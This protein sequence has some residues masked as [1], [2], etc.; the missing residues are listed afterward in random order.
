MNMEDL[1]RLLRTN[2]MPAQGIVNTTPDA[3]PRPEE[4]GGAILAGA[5]NVGKPIGER[6]L[7]VTLAKLI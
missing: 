7:L 2:H 3:Y 1:Y 4:I 5:V 6:H